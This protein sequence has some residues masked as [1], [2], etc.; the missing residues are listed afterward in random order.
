VRVSAKAKL[1]NRVSAKSPSANLGLARV[2]LHVTDNLSRLIDQ[3][4]GRLTVI[5][6][7]LGPFS[8]K[9]QYVFASSDP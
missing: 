3:I 7:R 4:D 1:F 6:Y 8:R 2:I 9:R 5:S